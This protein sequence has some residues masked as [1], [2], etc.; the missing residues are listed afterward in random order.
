M[1]YKI[2]MLGWLP[3][4]LDPRDLTVRAPEV[5]RSMDA[6]MPRLSPRGAVVAAAGPVASS[7]GPLRVDLRKW[8]SSVENQGSVGSCTANAVVGAYEYFQRRTTGENVEASRF[9]LY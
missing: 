1:G 8:C 2:P 9:F 4:P 5:V 3:D 6:I 7:V